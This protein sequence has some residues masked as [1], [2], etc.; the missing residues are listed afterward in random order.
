MNQLPPHVLMAALAQ[1]GMS[2]SHAQTGPPV[3]PYLDPALPLNYSDALRGSQGLPAPTQH[4]EGVTTAP[5]TPLHGHIARNQARNKRSQPDEPDEG[6]DTESSEE[7]GQPVPKRSRRSRKPLLRRAPLRFLYGVKEENLSDKQ[8]A[9]RNKLQVRL[10]IITISCS[11]SQTSRKELVH[12]ELSDLTGITKK[13]FPH[14]YTARIHRPMTIRMHSPT[15]C[16]MGVAFLTAAAFR[17]M[18]PS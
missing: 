10:T 2:P 5:H 17:S 15:P 11:E 1:L 6:L 4:A 3:P 13:K 7:D 14:T 8:L 16:Q 18:L 9:V 12:G